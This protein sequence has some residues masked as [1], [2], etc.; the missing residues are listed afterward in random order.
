MVD[1]APEFYPDDVDLEAPLPESA[2]EV[3]VGRT[4]FKTGPPSLVGVELEWLVYDADVPR[5]PVPAQRVQAALDGSATAWPASDGGHRPAGIADIHDRLT[6][7]PG[8]QLELSSP[9]A[10]LAQCLRDTAAELAVLRR[11]L[12]GDRLSLVGYGLDPVRPPLRQTD[13]PRYTAM[14]HH[15]D[16][17]GGAGRLMMCSTASVQVCLDAGADDAEIAARWRSMYALAPVLTALFA[18]SPLLEGRPT[19]WRCSRQAVWSQIDPSRTRPPA[20]VD[21]QKPS[22]QDGDPRAAY[23]RYALDA[24]VLAV[25]RPG[26]SWAAPAGLTFRDWARGHGPAQLGRPRLADLDY[27]LS[28]LFPPVRP[29]GH[30][31]LRVIDAQPED[32]WQ[33]VTAVVATLLDDP[34][35]RDEALAAAEPVA[36]AWSAAARSALT[37]PGLARAARAVLAAAVAGIR[38]AG[39]PADLVDAAERFAERFAARSRCPADDLL[40]AWSDDPLEIASRLGLPP[41]EP[42][43]GTRATT[44]PGRNG[45]GR[46]APAAAERVADRPAAPPYHADPGAAT[47]GSRAAERY[48]PRPQPT[49]GPAWE[50]SSR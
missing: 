33:L 30:L 37:D 47:N 22:T 2:A 34:V 16:R 8:G 38:R 12:A 40:S 3:Y 28:T 29:R 17:R 26:R 9:P 35:A 6:T 24:E 21:P 50:G 41:A 15:F 1:I 49:A 42:K 25:R 39:L 20:D 48:S 11:G 45:A 23:A 10:P 13:E 36:G 27:H 18:N 32:Q 14:E 7:E 44:A 31:E 5:L 46:R 19:G 43:P 4:A